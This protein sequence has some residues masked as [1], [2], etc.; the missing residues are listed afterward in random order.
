ML[1]FQHQIKE[2][3][4]CFFLSKETGGFQGG[5]RIQ[6]KK[7]KVRRNLTSCHVNLKVSTSM[8]KLYSNEANEISATQFQL[9]CW[10]CSL[11]VHT[12]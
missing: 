2:L 12:I 5:T 7:N 9:S 11:R 4:V 3:T 6:T 10:L 8:E 1:E